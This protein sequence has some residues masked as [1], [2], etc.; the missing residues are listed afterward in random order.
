MSQN[1]KKAKKN[2][3]SLIIITSKSSKRTEKTKEKKNKEVSFSSHASVEG[4]H[5]GPST[6][7]TVTVKTL[8][9]KMKIVKK[10]HVQDSDSDADDDCVTFMNLRG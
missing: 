10:A 3:S 2:S 9:T 7:E 1:P 4:P 5:G 8:V 6:R